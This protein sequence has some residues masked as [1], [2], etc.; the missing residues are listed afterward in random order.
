[1]NRNPPNALTLSRGEDYPNNFILPLASPES[2]VKLQRL[3]T[4]TEKKVSTNAL[5]CL[6]CFCHKW[7]LKV[8]DNMHPDKVP[9]KYPHII[10]HLPPHLEIGMVLLQYLPPHLEIGM[11]LLQ[12][13]RQF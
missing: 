11:V 13:F 4:K 8:Q 9:L 2:L 1:M 5:T 10:T 12:F 7:L 6:G 3:N